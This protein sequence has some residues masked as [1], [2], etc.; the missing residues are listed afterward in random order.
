[1]SASPHNALTR[2]AAPGPAP[3]DLHGPQ[4]TSGHEA[5]QA[6]LAFAALHEQVRV[7]SKELKL[8]HAPVSGVLQ[9][10]QFLLDE[11]LQ[12]VAE[13]A[14]TITGADGVAVAFREDSGIVCRAAA[15][16]I[17]PEIGARL[18][19]NSGF[20]GACL[21]GGEI[22]RCDD[23]ERDPRVNVQACRRLG[24]R[25]MVAVPLAA[26]ENVI[27]LLEVFSS[28]NYGFNDSDVR[29]LSLL[30]ELIMAAIRP[31]EEDRLAEVAP[32]DSTGM[33]PA[34]AKIGP[35]VELEIPSAA[36]AESGTVKIPSAD[37]IAADAINARAVSVPRT[38]PTPER[39]LR[40]TILAEYEKTGTARP[41]LVVVLI[42][43]L[44]AIG[45][46]AGLWWMLHH[47]AKPGLPA[48]KIAQSAPI[49]GPAT[50]QPA[51]AEATPPAQAAPHPSSI[52]R[53]TGIRHW[54][55]PESST[56][57]ID[58]EDQ[59]QY[60][61]HRLASPERIYFDLHD[62]ALSPGWFGKTIEIGDSLLLKIRVAQPVK[63]ITRV[64]LDTRNAPT[65]S[66]SLEPNPYRLVVEIRSGT[67]KMT[68][69]AKVALNSLPAVATKPSVVI[70]PEIG[71]FSSKPVLQQPPSPKSDAASV[72]QPYS[73][74]VHAQ[75]PRF[76]IVLDAGHG[77]WDLGTVGRK[78]LL[79]KDLVLDVVK[80]LG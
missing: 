1:M 32:K 8:Q 54:S 19:P 50:P 51:T 11:V 64:V 65:F 24:A 69:R 52:P 72:S 68:S 29:S 15:G 57:V 47:L 71:R 34:G 44:L 78:G 9:A 48:S 40:P 27:G 39:E 66:V 70:S 62:T 77:G 17:A 74:R 16:S 4:A 37:A 61:A 43:I 7:R 42:L 26:R 67:A 60:E 55:S 76:R 63:G 58:L 6:L 80:R 23:S 31:E 73:D 36:K 35:G 53:V 45:L 59:V 75:N 30:A 3:K 46:A 20:S 49:L 2:H 5:L 10:E 22:V 56:V 33:L 14:L 13:R 38:S 25:S 79:E 12:L 28:A 41:G 21:R 18:D